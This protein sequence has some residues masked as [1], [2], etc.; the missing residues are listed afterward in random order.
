MPWLYYKVLHGPL[1]V[2]MCTLSR[3][4]K[5]WTNDNST[6]I[7]RCQEANCLHDH[8]EAST[9]KGTKAVSG[10]CGNQNHSWGG[11]YI[12]L[13]TPAESKGGPVRSRSCDVSKSRIHDSLEDEHALLIEI[14]FR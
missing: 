4:L 1:M 13:V 2:H 6:R 8:P 14:M 10:V 3:A 5:G 12:D 11:R 9:W 7:T